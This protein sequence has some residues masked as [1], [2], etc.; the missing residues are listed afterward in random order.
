M[1]FPLSDGLAIV[2][3]VLFVLTMVSGWY[4]AAVASGIAL[5][6]TATVAH[7][8]FHQVNVIFVHSLRK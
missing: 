6:M 4:A 7:N 5:G 8:F 1:R 2:Y 3:H